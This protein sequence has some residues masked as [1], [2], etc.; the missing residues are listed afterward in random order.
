[1]C[2]NALINEYI[3]NDAERAV[4]NIGAVVYD[5]VDLSPFYENTPGDLY[6]DEK[7]LIELPT[8]T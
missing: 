6:I 8:P 4:T 2:S 7:D 5:S 1:M 3:A